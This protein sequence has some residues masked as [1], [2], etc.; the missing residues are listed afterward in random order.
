MRTLIDF[1]T[2]RIKNWPVKKSQAGIASD[3]PIELQKELHELLGKLSLPESVSFEDLVWAVRQQQGKLS[4]LD[5]AILFLDEWQ[6]LY[7]NR[8]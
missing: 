4:E 8:S 3:L 1:T 2:S 7:K 6:K 5:T